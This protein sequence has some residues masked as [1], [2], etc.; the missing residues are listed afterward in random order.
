MKPNHNEVLRDS[1]EAETLEEMRASIVKLHIVHHELVCDNE[2]KQAAAIDMIVDLKKQLAI[3]QAGD[4]SD[5]PMMI[6]DKALEPPLQTMKETY[7]T[8]QKTTG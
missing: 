2:R 1:L 6:R 3:A 4:M 7:E 8:K 5:V